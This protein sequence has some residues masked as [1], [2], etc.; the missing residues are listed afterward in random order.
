MSTLDRSGPLARQKLACRAVGEANRVRCRTMGY[1]V[2]ASPGESRPGSFPTGAGTGRKGN[3]LQAL[4]R[5][6]M[7]FGID[8]QLREPPMFR[9][10]LVLLAALALTAAPAIAKTPPAKDAHALAVPFIADDY[11][12]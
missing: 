10:S 9:K 2:P 12:T 5:C 1:R 3:S 8:L 11:E 6:L 4:P 7:L